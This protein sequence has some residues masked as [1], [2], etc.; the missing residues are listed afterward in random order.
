MQPQQIQNENSIQK[1]TINI[2]VGLFQKLNEKFIL[3]CLLNKGSNQFAIRASNIS[4]LSTSDKSV[5]LNT[6]KSSASTDSCNLVKSISNV[7]FSNSIANKVQVGTTKP[8][9]QKITPVL[10]TQ[11]KSV[12][13]P[14]KKLKTDKGEKCSDKIKVRRITI[15]PMRSDGKESIRKCIRKGCKRDANIKNEC[16]KDFCST[17]CLVDFCKSEFSTW[18]KNRAKLESTS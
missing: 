14:V 3:P 8:T 10:S 16:E 11:E 6:V 17:E 7:K 1:E 15:A 5:K 12:E 13:S 4:E 18:V 9:I 2:P